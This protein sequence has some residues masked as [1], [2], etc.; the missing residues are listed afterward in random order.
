MSLP[1]EVHEQSWPSRIGAGVGVGFAA[2]AH[3]WQR[4]C[5]PLNCLRVLDLQ[6]A[7]GMQS[8][9]G[10]RLP[11]SPSLWQACTLQLPAAH[12]PGL[13][14]RMC[15]RADRRCGVQLG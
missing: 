2:G 9:S 13:L 4:R 11:G 10:M 15:R 1:V 6:E 3:V 12:P 8:W 7:V 14:H 5:L